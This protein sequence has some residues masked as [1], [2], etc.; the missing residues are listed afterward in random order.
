M[1]QNARDTIR[2]MLI[3]LVAGALAA[4]QPFTPEQVMSAPTPSKLMAEPAG[5]KDGW[6]FIARG[7]RCHSSIL[8]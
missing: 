3:S 2:Y 8:S 5:G 4:E 7:E 6:R 1:K